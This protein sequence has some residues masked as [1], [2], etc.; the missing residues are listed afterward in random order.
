MNAEMTF[1]DVRAYCVTHRATVLID[2]D[3]SLTLNHEPVCTG[4]LNAA[5]QL[6]LNAD[7]VVHPPV[8]L[9]PRQ[10][11]VYLQAEGYES[12]ALVM[13]Q[14]FI[15]AAH[16]KGKERHAKPGEPFDQQMMQD[17]AK[18]FGVG[19]LLSQAF[20]KSEESQRLPLERGVNELLGAMVY[21]A[22]AVIA[23]RAAE[24]AANDN[25]GS[26]C[27]LAASDLKLPDLTH[28]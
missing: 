10:N 14:A 9:Q 4:K 1:N 7:Q 19:A 24:G 23:R 8:V 17:M 6:G 26:G 2:F 13:Q 21:L 18:R 5:V 20:K 22:G 3:G 16:G 28:G 27:S 25:G 12:L 15:Q 11:A